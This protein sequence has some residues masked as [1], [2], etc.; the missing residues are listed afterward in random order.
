MVKVQR[1]ATHAQAHLKAG[2]ACREHR[3]RCLT[4]CCCCRWRSAKEGDV[5]HA[6]Y[7]R[8]AELFLQ[9]QAM[10]KALCDQRPKPEA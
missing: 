4:G 2:V 6:P 1:E 8:L 10:T 5:N 3:C 9:V 7:A